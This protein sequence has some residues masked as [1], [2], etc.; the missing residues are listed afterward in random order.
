MKLVAKLAGLALLFS[1]QAQAQQAS[2]Y[3]QSQCSDEQLKAL[4]SD[5]FNLQLTGPKQSLAAA[6]L[7]ASSKQQ[8]SLESLSEL[9]AKPTSYLLLLESEATTS[10]LQRYSVDGKL[11]EAVVTGCESTAGF[12]QLAS[13]LRE[14]L[15]KPQQTLTAAT[16]LASLPGMDPYR[17]QQLLSQVF[18]QRGL[19]KPELP[20][21]AKLQDW[22]QA[23]ELA[24]PVEKSQVASRGREKIA[25][26]EIFYAT[27]RQAAVDQ[28]GLY[29]TG[30]R[31]LQQ[32]LTYGKATISFPAG[33]Q[34]FQ[35]ESPLLS[36]SFFEDAEEHVLIKSVA[37]ISQSDFF[38]K[39]NSHPRSADDPWDDSIIVYIHGFNVSFNNAVLRAGQLAFDYQFPGVPLLFSWPSD[40]ELTAYASDR[41]DATWSVRY[42]V[43]LLDELKTKHPNTPIHLIA[44]SMGNQVLLGALQQLALQSP[45]ASGWFKSAVLAAPDFDQQLFGYQM[46]SSVLPLVDNWAVYASENDTALM[47]SETVNS[48]ARLGQPHIAVAGVELIDASTLDVNLWSV[49]QTH[50]YYATQQPVADDIA[51][52]LQGIPASERDLIAVEQQG[53]TTWQIEE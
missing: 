47:V 53:Y 10:Y 49:P 6:Q 7:L 11:V 52:M 13:S 32:Q 33:H 28:Q 1:L 50:S 35:I 26:Q 2:F 21:A 14:F 31:S 27:N 19:A 48:V 8:M 18:S 41:E 23:L 25:L 5:Y 24:E 29:F 34:R 12:T 36:L 16:E 42:L 4:A 43:T 37:K 45:D 46:A 17:Q 40:G 9:A 3:N 51:L 15:A 20:G 44:H 22:L 39:I 38:T 30:E